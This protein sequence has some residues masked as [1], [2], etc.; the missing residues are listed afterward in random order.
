M[1]D[2][3]VYLSAQKT[4]I[5]PFHRSPDFV[6]WHSEIEDQRNKSRLLRTTLSTLLMQPI[7]IVA[8]P[9]C[10]FYVRSGAGIFQ[11]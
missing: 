4:K 6:L 1:T 2:Y 10:V 11:I 7:A 5:L 3:L 8:R 9:P